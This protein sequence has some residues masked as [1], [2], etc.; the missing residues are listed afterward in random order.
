M[1]NKRKS[2]ILAASILGSVAI[3]STGFAAWV[4]TIDK[5]TT[6][7]GNIEVDTVSD[8]SIVLT[9]GDVSKSIV[10][11]AREKTNTVQN[12]WL[13][14]SDTAKNENLTANVT[15]TVVGKE[16]L[17]TTT[18]FT[19]TL[20]EV[21]GEG[22]STPYAAAVTAGY[23]TSLDNVSVIFSNVNE[24]NQATVTL[25]FS[26]GTY[27]N[28]TNPIDF[29]NTYAADA[30]RTESG[31]TYAEEAETVLGS[32]TFKNLANAKFKLTVTPKRKN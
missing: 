14:Y 8:G 10:F 5:G 24:D 12:S 2:I 6:A 19:Y 4:I 30:K 27:F 21:A 3:V 1:K 16:Y 13:V 7:T 22:N 11:G 23:V 20:E 31:P 15:L 32:D 29:Y 18:P 17:D 28:N 9:A 25:T 26:W